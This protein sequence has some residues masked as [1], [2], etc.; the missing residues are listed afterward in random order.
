MKWTMREWGGEGSNRWIITDGK[1]QFDIHQLTDGGIRP[2]GYDKVIVTPEEA[3][4]Y[5]HHILAAL[6]AYDE[7]IPT[8]AG[9]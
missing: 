3:T 8:G 1:L 9:R 5:A 4:E 2:P 7:P 6:N